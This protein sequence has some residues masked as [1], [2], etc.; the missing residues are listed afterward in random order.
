LRQRCLR[1]NQFFQLLD[2]AQAGLEIHAR[3]RL[4]AVERL[5]VAVGVKSN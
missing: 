3:K 4:A 2:R 1:G 5:A